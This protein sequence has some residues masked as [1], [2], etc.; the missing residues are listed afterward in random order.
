MEAVT[1]I[2][3]TRNRSD[4]LHATLTS[5]LRQRDV[6]LD[7]VVVDDGSAREEDTAN[8]VKRLA[9][10]RIRMVRH[11]V[12]EGV[13]AARN[14]GVSE[15]STDWVAFCDDDDL[16]SPEKLQQ[17]VVS[18]RA[19]GRDWAYAGCVFVNAH[20]EIRGGSP[21]PSAEA[22]RPALRRYN[23]VPAGA[24]NVVVRT[25]VMRQI[26]GFDT[27]LTHVP[28]WDLW[29]RLAAHGVP[30]CVDDPLVGYRMHAGNAS[31]RTGEM[32][33]E[34]YGLEQRYGLTMTRGPFHRHLAHLCLKSGRRRE[35][36]LH[37]MRALLRFRDGYSRLDLSTDWRI[38]RGHAAEISR[39]RLGVPRSQP[40]ATAKDPNAAWKAKAEVWLQELR[41]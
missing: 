4:F 13:S 36:V 21:P 17:Q 27:R 28:D 41:Q 2:V 10:R 1:V 32:L 12:S 8:A 11:P 34:L 5:I 7:V 23:A 15:A 31:F 25:E 24:S 40:R 6:D 3:P 26:G 37:F 9:D 18:A 38:L 16:W 14:R 35:A 30:A 39:R 20:L 22:I 29:L 33:T 19:L